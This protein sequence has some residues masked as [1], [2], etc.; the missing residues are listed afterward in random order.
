MASSSG[1]HNNGNGVEVFAGPCQ[2]L[3]QACAGGFDKVYQAWDPVLKG[4]A[5]AQLEVVGFW[6]RRAQ[7]Y[8][9]IPSRL[10]QVRGPQDLLAEQMRFWQTA[11]TQYQDSSRKLM[12]LYAA[13]VP[14]LPFSEPKRTRTQRDYISVPEADDTAQVGAGGRRAA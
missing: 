12:K 10:Q 9:D 4:A 2:H 1:N 3:M 6:N 7:A 5:Q 14:E 13:A 8:L 11:F